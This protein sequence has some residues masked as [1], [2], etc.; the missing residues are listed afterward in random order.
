M[1][2]L[3]DMIAA[4]LADPLRAAR[5]WAGDGGRVVG[6][7]GADTPTEPVLG[8]G[9]LPVSLL[10]A[11]RGEASEAARYF[12]PSF[13]PAVRAV[14]ARW[15]RGELDAFE[16]VVFS[17]GDDSA[18]RAYY[19]LCELQRRGQVGGPLPL[20]FD[21]AKIARASSLAHTEGSL[22]GLAEQLRCDA[23]S[24]AR[25]LE[26]RNRRRALLERLDRLRCSERSPPGS[27]CAELLGAA[28]LIAPEPFDAALACWLDGAFPPQAGARVLLAGSAPPDA[29]LHRAVE[30]GGGCVV[31]ELEGDSAA[32]AVPMPADPTQTPAVLARH[33]QG[34]ALGAR[35]C[36]DRAAQLVSRARQSSAQAV[37]LW[38]IEEDES[39]VWQL[40][41]MVTALTSVQLPLLTLT[42]QR[43]DLQSDALERVTA[44]TRA[45][46]CPT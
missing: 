29:R 10:A 42:R 4:A 21:V 44:F 40:P 14:A 32:R 17:R 7:V 23:V 33:Y 38:L 43:W 22:R 46:A 9:A 12:E 27:L 1:S 8:V 25:G 5:A 45:L 20:I 19:Y 13:L 35:S 36:V 24:L 41:E 11:A 2:T 15:L 34:L 37:I 30:S 26:M 16:A 39:L 3:P 18:Q 6:L 28:E 31:A